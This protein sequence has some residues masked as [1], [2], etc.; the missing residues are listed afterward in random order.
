MINL[1]GDAAFHKIQLAFS[2]LWMI[3]LLQLNWL[4]MDSSLTCN[5][6]TAA[7]VRLFFIEAHSR[8]QINIWLCCSLKN[9][10]HLIHNL[11]KLYK[12]VIFFI[13][14]THWLANYMDHS[15]LIECLLGTYCLINVL[16]EI[17]CAAKLI[18]G[19]YQS[20][21]WNAIQWDK[22]TVNSIDIGSSRKETWTYA[23]FL[24][25]K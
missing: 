5:E 14:G 24:E 11:T 21:D 8:L 16:S 17:I 7:C 2:M 22:L 3:W 6:I 23:S 10:L 15:F 13:T 1:I 9:V 25:K 20:G 4:R 18:K 12:I 19:G